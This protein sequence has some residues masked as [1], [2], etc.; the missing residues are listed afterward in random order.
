MILAY[1]EMLKSAFEDFDIDEMDKLM[2]ELSSYK[3][4]A[5]IESNIEKLAV[6]VINMDNE[7]AMVLIEKIIKE[8]IKNGV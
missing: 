2:N 5:E 4:P 8:I 3:Y 7:A 6:Q 1:L